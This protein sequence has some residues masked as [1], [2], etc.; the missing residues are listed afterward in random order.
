MWYYK[1]PAEGG[2]RTPFGRLMSLYAYLVKNPPKS[3]KD[4]QSRTFFDRNMRLPVFDNDQAQRMMYMWIIIH[5]PSKHRRYL[6]EACEDPD[7]KIVHTQ[8]G[9][10]TDSVIDKIINNVI[11]KTSSAFSGPPNPAISN[12]M[13]SISGGFSKIIFL[14][15][16]LTDP[17]TSKFSQD[18]GPAIGFAV[19]S[20]D[21]TEKLAH[22]LVDLVMKPLAL[23]L[24]PVPGSPIIIEIWKFLNNL[25]VSTP[26]IMMNISMR[27]F[28]DAATS[29]IAAFPGGV[30]ILGLKNMLDQQYIKI[31]AKRETLQNVPVVGSLLTD[32]HPLMLATGDSRFNLENAKKAFAGIKEK[33]QE[34]TSKLPA[35]QNV[36]PTGISMHSYRPKL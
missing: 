4:L 22:D 9:G 16:N 8:K 26:Y 2:D 20:L 25:I 6:A 15:H 24:A 30:S 12:V 5:D 10:G 23:L 35:F 27:N 21:S 32:L 11:D 28:A 33:I 29:F 17:N 3:A 7:V 14:L 31:K 36:Q 13:S 1:N 18:F 34:G 19:D